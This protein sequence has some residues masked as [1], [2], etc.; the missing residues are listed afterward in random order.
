MADMSKEQL[1]EEEER[2]A[3][4]EFKVGG[5]FS[6]RSQKHGLQYMKQKLNLPLLPRPAP[7]PARTPS[8]ASIRANWP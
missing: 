5:S 1:R 8:S 3:E 7:C 6:M 4:A 2:R